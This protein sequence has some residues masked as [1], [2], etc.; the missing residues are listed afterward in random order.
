[1]LCDLPSNRSLPTSFLRRS[2]A[3]LPRPPSFRH[4]SSPLRRH[5]PPFAALI[6]H[7]AAAARCC[8]PNPLLHCLANRPPPTKPRPP[9]ANPPSRSSTRLL[10]HHRSRQPR[11]RPSS[12]IYPASALG[13][14]LLSSS[15]AIHDQ[16][17]PVVILLCPCTIQR[18]QAPRDHRFRPVDCPFDAPS[19]SRCPPRPPTLAPRPSSPAIRH[20]QS[21]CP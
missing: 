20:P 17:S 7:S 8:P 19:V 1:L 9:D 4:S 13:C 6:L 18:R 12:H 3:L 5:L 11:R 10:H 2:S 21:T 15:L 14:N 16:S